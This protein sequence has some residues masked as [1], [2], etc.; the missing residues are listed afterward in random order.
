MLDIK[1]LDRVA[2]RLG[3]SMQPAGDASADF[4]EAAEAE[5]GEPA[6]A[7]ENVVLFVL[8]QKRELAALLD[9]ILVGGQE[10]VHQRRNKAELA[11]AVADDRDADQAA[12]AP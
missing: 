11:M 12:L 1:I 2:D 8:A 3:R 10:R 4:G 6:G 9:A 5:A 7:A